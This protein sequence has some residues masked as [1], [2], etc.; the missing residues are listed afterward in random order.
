[1]RYILGYMFPAKTFYLYGQYNNGRFPLLKTLKLPQENDN[2][3]LSIEIVRISYVFPYNNHN[4]I[5]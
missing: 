4:C 2:G 1:M 3:T 5:N